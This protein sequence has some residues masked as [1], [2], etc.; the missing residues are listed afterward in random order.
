M[1]D[2]LQRAARHL[3]S[4][5]DVE[6][7]WALGARAVEL[8]LAGHGGVMPTIVR[9]SDVPYQWMLEWRHWKTWPM[10]KNSCQR[11]FISAEGFTSD[12]SPTL[13]GAADSG[14]GL[15]SRLSMV[16]HTMC[17]CKI[18][19]SPPVAAVFIENRPSPSLPSGRNGRMQAGLSQCTGPCRF[20][21]VACP[22]QYPRLTYYFAIC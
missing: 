16:C 2:Y 17:A 15:A 5:V 9:L 13:P 22:P 4:A 20:A 21:T 19:Q 3:A 14:R 11:E 18:A 10:W 8:A 1:A 7:A 6:Q 12:A